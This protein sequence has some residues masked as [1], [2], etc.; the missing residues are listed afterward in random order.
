MT[1]EEILDITD[2]ATKG[3]AIIINCDIGFMVRIIEQPDGRARIEC[4][5]DAYP[6]GGNAEAEHVRQ[7]IESWTESLEAYD[8]SKEVAEMVAKQNA[9]LLQKLTPVGK[10]SDT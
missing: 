2:A 3:K 1:E 8:S 5:I 4:P 6:I 7:A 10:M 9:L